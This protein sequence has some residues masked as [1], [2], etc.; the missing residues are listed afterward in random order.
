MT[1]DTVFD[2]CAELLREVCISEE[3]NGLLLMKKKNIDLSKHDFSSLA[4]RLVD[5][6]RMKRPE[7]SGN[8]F[9][10]MLENVVLTRVQEGCQGSSELM[11]ENV[12]LTIVQEGCQGSREKRLK[13]FKLTTSTRLA[14]DLPKFGKQEYNAFVDGHYTC[15]NPFKARIDLNPETKPGELVY[16][17]FLNTPSVDGQVVSVYLPTDAYLAVDA[18]TALRKRFD[19]STSTEV[20]DSLLVEIFGAAKDAH[21]KLKEHKLITDEFTHKNLEDLEKIKTGMIL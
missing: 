8:F 21:E 10:L 2:C 6:R 18:L 15:S 13:Q 17:V 14:A 5:R 20:E 9:K 4:G 11:L 12:E 1:A 3:K 19:R 16:S 7:Q